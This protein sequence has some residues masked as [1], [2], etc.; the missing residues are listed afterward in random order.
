MNL[1]A[2]T[3]EAI[4]HGGLTEPVMQVLFAALAGRKAGPH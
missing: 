4:I 2:S 1:V 3:D